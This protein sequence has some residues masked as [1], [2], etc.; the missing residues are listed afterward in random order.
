MPP[1]GKVSNRKNSNAAGL[2]SFSSSEAA[3]ADGARHHQLS[4]N[5]QI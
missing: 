3:E 1:E 2:Y 5:P 4:A